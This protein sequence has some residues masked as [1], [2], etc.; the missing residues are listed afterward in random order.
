MGGLDGAVGRLLGDDGTAVGRVVGFELGAVGMSL[1]VEEGDGLGTVVGSDGAAERG[2]SEGAGVGCS[3]GGP[4]LI[5]W[6]E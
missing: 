3:E 1:G 6:R 2:F 4:S 5:C